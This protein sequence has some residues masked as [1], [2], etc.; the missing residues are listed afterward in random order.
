MKAS[1]VHCIYRTNHRGLNLNAFSIQNYTW[2]TCTD[3]CYYPKVAAAK[4][5]APLWL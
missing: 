1:C 4:N 5:A 3:K 2:A